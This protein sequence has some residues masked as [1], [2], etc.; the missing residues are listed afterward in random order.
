V[1]GADSDCKPAAAGQNLLANPGGEAGDLSGWTVLQNGG[2]GWLNAT[3]NCHSGAR[4]FGTSYS[5]C[6][7]KQEIDLVAKGL[8]A[9]YLDTQPPIYV[10]EWVR[11]HCQTGDVYQIQVQLQNAS[12]ATI[13]S[14]DTGQVAFNSGTTG[15]N[16]DDDF[17]QEVKKTFS[18]YGAGVRYVVFVDLGRD[19]EWW[20]GYYGTYF[21]DAYVKV[22]S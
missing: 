4:C 10:G 13:A 17:W 19:Y 20:A 16:S 18:G 14:W 15:C 6:Q 12:R 8:P 3:G 11:E 7:R 9:A 5:D 1:D 2:D 22:G 21:D